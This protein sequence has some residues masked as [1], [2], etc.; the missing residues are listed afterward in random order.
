MY[1]AEVVKK[2]KE[3][4]QKKYDNILQY[5]FDGYTFKIIAVHGGIRDACRNTGADF[6]AL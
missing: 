1:C 3:T 2:L 4:H 6:R 5:D